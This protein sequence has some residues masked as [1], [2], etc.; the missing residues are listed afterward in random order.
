MDKIGDFLT[1]LRNALALSKTE[2]VVPYS[3]LKWAIAKVLKEEG[4]L[5]E[6]KK[7]GKPLSYKLVI[8]PAY[9]KNM[10]LIQSIQR[11]SRP[12][13]RV[14]RKA[15]LLS[16]SSFRGKTLVVSTSR[17]VISGR[18]AKKRH[19]GGEIICEVE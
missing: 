6:L 8:E 7:T 18:E 16:R 10:P 2:V 11:V 19:L 17:G 9:H 14:Y 3:R 12:S 5:Q 15:N 13:L 4:F 1:T